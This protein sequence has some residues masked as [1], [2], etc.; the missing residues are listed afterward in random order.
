MV[1]HYLDYN[2]LDSLSGNTLADTVIGA[3]KRQFTCHGILDEVINDNGPQFENHE[4]SRFGRAYSFA[5]VKSSPYYSWENG[6]AESAVKI[7]KNILKKSWTEDPY[8]ALLAYRNTPPL[9]LPWT[10]SHVKKTQG[11]CRNANTRY[12]QI[13]L[14]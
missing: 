7:A 4:Y 14:F 6:K 2:E 9:L 11:Y 12:E 5:I 13:I 10:M 8:L 3:M 1:D